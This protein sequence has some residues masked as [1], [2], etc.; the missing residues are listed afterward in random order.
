MGDVEQ[1][2]REALATVRETIG[3]FRQ[4]TLAAELAGA[5][6]ALAAAGIDGR[7]EPAPD[8]IPPAVDAVLGWAVREG[9][10]NIVRHGRAASAVIRIELS[11]AAAGVDIWNDRLSSEPA[12]PAPAS[13]A[14]SGLVGLSER[15]A[16]FG[17]QVDAG[18]VDGG[19]FRLH[20]SVPIA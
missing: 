15:V 3:G 5:R 20:V 19:G 1:V 9:V 2:A 11:D 12:T 14:G 7:V 17:G 6:S 18:P 16:A 8:G 13:S 10:T 4:P